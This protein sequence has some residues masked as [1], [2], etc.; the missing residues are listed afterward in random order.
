MDG[1]R[2][3]GPS[4]LSST[5]VLIKVLKIGGCLSSEV[6]QVWLQ[7]T[8]SN[9]G[10]LVRFLYTRHFWAMLMSN[11]SSFNIWPGFLWRLAAAGAP[12]FRSGEPLSGYHVVACFAG[13][14]GF[15]K[16]E[17]RSPKAV[18]S[19]GGVWFMAGISYPAELKQHTIEEAWKIQLQMIFRVD[20]TH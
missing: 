11:V 7:Q 10:K 2:R 12:S 16:V 15:S 1:L 9:W 8:H 17:S 4:K 3:N 14:W 20:E 5:Q 6:G 18:W 13:A 19:G